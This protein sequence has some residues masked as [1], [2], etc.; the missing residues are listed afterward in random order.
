MPLF[1]GK[2]RGTVVENQDP[3]G[4]GRLQVDV[5]S[6]SAAGS[7]KWAMP[8]VPYAGPGVGLFLIPPREAHVWVEFEAGDPDF[9]I[10]TGCFWEEGEVPTDEAKPSTRVFKSDGVSLTIKDESGGSLELIVGKPIAD[11]EVKVVLGGD[12]AVVETGSG[13]IEIT[14]SQVALNSDGLVVK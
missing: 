6:V 3:L 4:L 5:P 10:W 8:C 12:G 14:S 2:Y 1:F 7:T 13:K 9:P 11:T